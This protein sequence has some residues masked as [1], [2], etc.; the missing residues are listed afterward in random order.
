VHTT[1]QRDPI[2][3]KK[4]TEAR[5]HKHSQLRQNRR[6]IREKLQNESLSSSSEDTLIVNGADYSFCSPDKIKLSKKKSGTA[7]WIQ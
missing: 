3:K 7:L 4:Q 2:K 5:G 1:K 6:K